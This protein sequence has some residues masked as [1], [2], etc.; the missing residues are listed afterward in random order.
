MLHLFHVS[1]LA[2][3]IDAIARLACLQRC[4]PRGWK[5]GLCSFVSPNSHPWNS[6]RFPFP[7][8]SRTSKFPPEPSRPD[9][10]SRGE[11]ASICHRDLIRKDLDGR[12]KG[13][14]GRGGSRPAPRATIDVGICT[15]PSQRRR[16]FLPPFEAGK[17]LQTLDRSLKSQARSLSVCQAHRASSRSRKMASIRVYEGFRAVA[18]GVA[19]STSSRSLNRSS[20]ATFRVVAQKKV[21]KTRQV[22]SGW[23][24]MTRASWRTV[25]AGAKMASGDGV[26]TTI[27]D[28]AELCADMCL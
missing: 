18:P 14:D 8:R 11:E 21:K 28:V 23:V 17:R 2:C 5:C 15:R 16:T 6:Y 19:A 27:V 4:L 9:R 12:I 7:C 13:L 22:C 24:N 3:S 26:C 25:P 20:G 1:G 10:G